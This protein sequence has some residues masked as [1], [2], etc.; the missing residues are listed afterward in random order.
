MLSE[1]FSAIVAMRARPHH[2]CLDAPRVS[3]RVRHYQPVSVHQHPCTQSPVSKVGQCLQAESEALRPRNSVV[4]LAQCLT[5]LIARL[6]AQLQ[7]SL[8]KDRGKT[9]VLET[10]SHRFA[11]II[12][13]MRI[14][15]TVPRKLQHH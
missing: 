4:R 1:S 11:R 5:C 10:D 9:W 7:T 6:S 3:P 15:V 8:T 13:P 14:Y 2:I 12:D